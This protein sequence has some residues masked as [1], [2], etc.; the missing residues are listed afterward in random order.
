MNKIFP[1]L[2][3]LPLS[4]VLAGLFFPAH[5]QAQAPKKVV[6]G[7]VRDS[8]GPLAKATISEKGMPANATSSGPNGEFHLTLKGSSSTIIITYV[9]F[10][11]EE[12]RIKDPSVV[13]RVLLKPNDRGLE[14]ATVVGFGNVKQRATE[15]GAVSSIQAKEIEDVPTSNVQN[16]LVGEVSGFV[17][18]QRSGQPG[19]DGADFYIRGVSSLNSAANQPLILVDDIEYT[20]DQ[21]QQINVQEIESVTLLKDASSTA[22]Y[23]I[24]GASGVVLIT[25]KRGATGKPHFDV[26]L[27]TGANAAVITPKFLDSYHSALL[28]NEAYNNDGLTPLYTSADLAAFKANND[29]YGHPNVNWYKAIIQP[30]TEQANADLDISGGTSNIKYFINAGAFTQNGAVKDFSTDALGINSNYF[31]NRY[32]IRSNLDIQAT[33]NFSIRVDATT[34]W[35]DQNIP[36]GVNVIGDIYNYQDYHPFSAPFINPNGS[37]AYAVDEVSQLPTLN[38]LLATQGYTRD[39]RTDFNVLTGFTEKLGDITPGL[40]LTGRVAYASQ[41]ENTLNVWTA[42]NNPPSYYYN[43]VNQTYTRNTGPNGGGYAL[44]PYLTTAGTDIDNQ[45]TNV[46]VF[47]NYDRLFNAAHHINSLLLWNQDDFRDDEGSTGATPGVPEKTEGYS[48]KVGYDFKQRYLADFNAG[49]NGSSRFGSGHQFGFFPAGG[50]GWN[51]AK[52]NFWIPLEHTISLA[53]LRASYGLVGSDVALGNQYLYQQ[54]YNRGANYSFGASPQDQGTISEGSLGNNNV[55]WQKSRKYDIGLDL[56]L[57]GSK[58]TSTTDYFHEHVYNQLVVPANTPLILGITL[59]PTNVGITQN[60][61]WEETLNYHDKVGQVSYSVGI[62]YTHNHNKILYE[63]EAYPAY[64]WLAVTGHQINQ[65]FGYVSIGYY[66]PADVNNPK[67]AKPNTAIPIQAGD[68]KYKDLNGDGSID[69]NDEKAIGNPNVPNTTI[70]LPLKLGYK[71]FSLAVLFQG[72]FDYSLSLY[73]T[74]IEPFQS[75]WQPIHEGAWTLANDEHATFPRLTSNPTT[76]N[77]PAVYNSTYWLVNAHYI[78]L[79]SLQFNYQLSNKALPLHIHSA[80]VYVSAYNLFTWSNVIHKYQQDPE[81]SSNTVGDAYINQRVLNIG[82]Q[83]GL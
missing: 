22:I 10:T 17:A 40:Q 54:I 72:A 15:T 48:L 56:N 63:A 9:N 19:S 57:F 52:E 75:Q 3:L 16:A 1:Y 6:S 31:Y 25:T 81:V 55:T 83:V 77:S 73:G 68:L 71:N 14:E 39:R 43:P 46:Q 79:K 42:F 21:L 51:M 20:Y 28:A 23:G 53:K 44:G 59:S 78:R 7:F 30:I 26:R 82:L 69:Q 13:V 76:I 5:G 70:G 33:R 18:V 67:V 36:F 35:L 27:E 65:P 60:L 58:L 12:I 41:E 62:V 47:L 29:P 64:P 2:F 45:R 37:Y 74:A 38:A 11:S 24:K 4:L 66:L 32:T 61:G 49:Y 34:R 8:A 80:R 50:V